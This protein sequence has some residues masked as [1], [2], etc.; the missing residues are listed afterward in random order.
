MQVPAADAGDLEYCTLLGHRLH[1]DVAVYFAA[2][3]T[4][5]EYLKGADLATPFHELAEVFQ[6]YHDKDLWIFKG[7][8]SNTDL[9]KGLLTSRQQSQALQADN[10]MRLIV[11]K[12][13]RKSK[14]AR[15]G[16][17]IHWLPAVGCRSGPAA[18]PTILCVSGPTSI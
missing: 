16:I 4:L 13:R 7:C 15:A 17:C 6:A 18:N 2:L 12:W 5:A 11:I 9:E 10:S 14:L 3:R 1:I 8:S